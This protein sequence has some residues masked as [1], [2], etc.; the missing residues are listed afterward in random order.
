M[1]EFI[2]NDVQQVAL[3]APLVLNNSIRCQKGYILHENGSAIITLRGIVN[4]P[5]ACFARYRVI[6]KSNIAIP[7][8]G[9]VTPIGLAIALQG[10]AQP[11]SRAIITPAAVEEYGNAVAI[12][13]VDV[14]K[15]CCFTLSLRYVQ[16]TDDPATTPTPGIE[17][18]NTI[19][20]IDRTA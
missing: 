2:Y 20:I 12:A 3:N 15:G 9:A 14:P 10:E 7:T 17:A 19:V 1:A 6:A 13:N 11:S 18:Q 16:A 8:G 5:Y 4:N